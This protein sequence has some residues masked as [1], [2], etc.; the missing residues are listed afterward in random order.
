MIFYRK[1]KKGIDRKNNGINFGKNTMRLW[2]QMIWKKAERHLDHFHE[3][4]ASTKRI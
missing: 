1:N 2:E 4:V 3:N